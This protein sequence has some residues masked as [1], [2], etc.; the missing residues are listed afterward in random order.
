MVMV[1]P[2]REWIYLCRPKNKN[3]YGND[4]IIKGAIFRKLQIIVFSRLTLVLPRSKA[5]ISPS[6]LGLPDFIPPILLAPPS[7]MIINSLLK[8]ESESLLKNIISFFLRNS[9]LHKKIACVHFNVVSLC[10]SHPRGIII[11]LKF[12]F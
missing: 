8:S 3:T 12:I 4:D 11:V 2:F 7:Y 9:V 1:C 6:G 5:S 10:N